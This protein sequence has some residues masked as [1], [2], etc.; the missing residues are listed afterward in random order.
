MKLYQMG[1]APNPRRLNMFLAE[2]GIEVPK[3]EIDTRKREQFGE[4]FTRIN[5]MRQIPALELDDGMVLTESVAICHYF[6]GLHPE[7][8]LLGKTPL[9]VATIMMWERRMEQHG[10]MPVA[11]AFRNGNPFYEGHA[12]SG[13]EPL[14]QIPEL[15][16]RGLVRIDQFYQRLD[17]FLDGREW[18]A[19]DRLTLAD[20]T[21]F[22]AADF[23]K[24]V[25]KKPP[26][27]LE[28]LQRWYQA[29]RSRPS[30]RA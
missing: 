14:P 16:E 12:V 19:A 9:E 24:V 5:P 28:N 26:E 25:G 1:L 17:G 10:L 21:G 7:P 11:D 27:N 20:I 13:G 4:D 23:A 29:I 2:K 6:E 30:A 8:N 18:L 3:I 22:V 15:A